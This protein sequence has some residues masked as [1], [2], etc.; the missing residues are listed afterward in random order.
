[1]WFFGNFLTALGTSSPHGVCTSISHPLA[2]TL[3]LLF[4]PALVL[5]EQDRSW[6]GPAFQG[7]LLN[8]QDLHCIAGRERERGLSCE[9][10]PVAAAAPAEKWEGERER[11]REREASSGPDMDS[12]RASERPCLVLGRIPKNVPKNLVWIKP[13]KFSLGLLNRK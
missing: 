11:G 9:D 12:L 2:L 8:K 7:I 4:S 5:L 6:K 3:H 10:G 1:M 13:L